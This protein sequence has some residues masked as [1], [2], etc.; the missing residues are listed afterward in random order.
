MTCTHILTPKICVEF[1]SGGWKTNP[2]CATCAVFARLFDYFIILIKTS[3]LSDAR[4]DQHNS[5]GDA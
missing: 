3:F 5:H 4:G 1:L 2:H